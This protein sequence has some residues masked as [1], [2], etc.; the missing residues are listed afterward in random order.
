MRI[1]FNTYKPYAYQNR[2]NNQTKPVST[3]K[4]TSGYGA[5]DWGCVDETELENCSESERWKNIGIAL[6]EMTVDAFKE[7][8]CS[9][10]PPKP[11]LYS[12]E[13]CKKAREEF[14]K[15]TDLE[16]VDTSNRLPKEDPFPYVFDPFEDDF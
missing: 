6:K 3:P 2:I 13:E 12:P 10:P 7:A 1:S 16:G 9:D 11:L 15:G 8:Y 14:Y 4:F 5:D